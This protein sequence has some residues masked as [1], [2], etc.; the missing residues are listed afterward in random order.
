MTRTRPT[1][2]G[3]DAPR[4]GRLGG[5]RDRIVLG[6]HRL[7]E[8]LNLTPPEFG[9]EPLA[10]AATVRSAWRRYLRLWEDY[11]PGEVFALK[12]GGVLVLTTIAAVSLATAIF[13]L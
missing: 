10:D 8:R 4:I 1:A 9:A 2:P 12:V 3:R 6:L 13:F 11:N 7:V 5:V